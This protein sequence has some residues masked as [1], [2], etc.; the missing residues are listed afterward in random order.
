VVFARRVA[1]GLLCLLVRIVQLLVVAVA[2]LAFIAAGLVM[3]LIALAIL[4]FM[5]A[6][7]RCGGAARPRGCAGAAWSGASAHPEQLR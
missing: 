6:E 2:G 1:I 3:S 4:A 5:A 7:A